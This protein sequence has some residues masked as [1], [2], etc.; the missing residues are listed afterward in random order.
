[1][2]ID[3]QFGSIQPYIESTKK[4]LSS[5][6]ISHLSPSQIKS[7]MQ[8]QVLDYFLANNDTKPA[9]FIEVDGEILGTDKEQALK[10][11]SPVLHQPK[12][13]YTKLFNAWSN[14]SVDLNLNDTLPAIER[15][16]K[17][18]GPEL[19]EI[20]KPYTA[21]LSDEAKQ[22]L[23]GLVV[24]RK[25]NLKQDFETYYTTLQNAKGIPGKFTFGKKVSVEDPSHSEELHKE[26]L[27]KFKLPTELPPQTEW[28]NDHEPQTQLDAFQHSSDLPNAS[29]L[30]F[31][32]SAKGLGGAKEKSFLKDSKGNTFLWKPTDNKFRAE[33]QQA[34]S[35]LSSLFLGKGE[36]IPVK[37]TTRDDKFGSIQPY[38]ENVKGDLSQKDLT[39]LT[40]KQCNDLL[41]ER[42]VD[43]LF[44][45]HDTHPK[46]FIELNDGSILGVDK[47][48]SWKHIGDDVLSTTYH[49]NKV[50][51]ESPPIYN[52][53]FDLYTK[54]KT[55]LDLKSVEPLFDKIDAISDETW[56]EHCKPYVDGLIASQPNKGVKAKEALMQ[57]ILDRK[58]NIKKDFEKFFGEL[59]EK[60]AKSYEKKLAKAQKKVEAKVTPKFFVTS[61][62]TN[63]S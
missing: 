62:Q 22:K 42:V 59:E 36:Y 23:I 52:K 45:N 17:I 55:K 53:L 21:H 38:L 18:T 26:K 27:E 6:P 9:N 40:E 57:K 12:S 8:E 19:E 47:E 20:L 60:H 54:G 15:A 24:A 61:T 14:G 56:K 48:Q 11:E 58:H 44:S 43:W 28:T 10:N 13:L 16:Q 33:V 46:Q 34:V 51:D 2:T 4:D 37:S 49:P 32:G 25:D 50:Y 1:V 29:A 35:D 30:K 3:G 31:A 41:R 5:T 39:K 63:P 7:V